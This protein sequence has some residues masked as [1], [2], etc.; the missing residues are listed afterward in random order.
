ML[1][2]FIIEELKKRERLRR[3]QEKRPVLELPK[4]D[5]EPPCS[6][7]DGHSEK[8]KERERSRVIIIDYGI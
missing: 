3:R 1:D 5:G 7:S 4:D 8:E 6:N 2:A